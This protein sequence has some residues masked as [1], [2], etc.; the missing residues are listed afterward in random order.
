VVA[1]FLGLLELFREG[2]VS[3]EQLSPLGDL[4]VRWTGREAGSV[5]IHDEF[6]EEGTG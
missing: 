6:D 5:N 3:F 4:T 1:R 2:Q